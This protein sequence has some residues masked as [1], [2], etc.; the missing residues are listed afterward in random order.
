MPSPLCEKHV[1]NGI[2]NISQAFI[3]YW[4]PRHDHS[5]NWCWTAPAVKSVTYLLAQC[6]SWPG[7]FTSF[8]RRPITTG[9][10]SHTSECRWQLIIYITLQINRQQIWKEHPETSQDS[11]EIFKLSQ[12]ITLT[13]D[14]DYDHQQKQFPK[15][16]PKFSLTTLMSSRTNMST[17]KCMWTEAVTD[18]KLCDLLLGLRFRITEPTTKP[19]LIEMKNLTVIILKSVRL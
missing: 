12:K 3:P 19:K 11:D 4:R 17:D 13:M 18:Y 6:L 1:V 2:I 8:P 7:A 5:W 14:W 16:S 9:A 10:W 15:N